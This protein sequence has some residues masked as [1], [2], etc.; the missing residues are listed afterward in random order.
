MNIHTIKYKIDN[1]QGPNAEHREL[2]SIFSD[3]LYEKGILKRM[4]ICIFI[5][6]SLCHTL[7]T[8]TTLQ[9]NYIPI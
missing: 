3:S 5:T 1:Q 9:I 2:Y 6:E 4:N 8:N 7:E